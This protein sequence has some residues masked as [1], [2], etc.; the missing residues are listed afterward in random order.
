M[1]MLEGGE[2]KSQK[3]WVMNVFWS[4]EVWTRQMK[5]AS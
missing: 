5:S 4:K 3:R 2:F 1:L